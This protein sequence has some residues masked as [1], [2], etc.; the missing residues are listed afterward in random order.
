MSAGERV[1]SCDGDVL[2]NVGV[3]ALAVVRKRGGFAV[4][5]L[6]GL[7]YGTA[8]DGEDALPVE[9]RWSVIWCHVKSEHG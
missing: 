7:C 4:E 5:D 6:A 2:G 8:K 3:D 9:S 1:I